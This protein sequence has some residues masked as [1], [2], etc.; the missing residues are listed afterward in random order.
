MKHMSYVNLLKTF[1][2]HLVLEVHTKRLEHL[3]LACVEQTEKS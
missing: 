2:L 1:R 3:T